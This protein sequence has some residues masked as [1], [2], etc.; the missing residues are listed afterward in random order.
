MGRFHALSIR[1]KLL[2][3]VLLPM[4]GVLPLLGALLLWWSSEAFDRLL[5]T[6]V[7]ADLAVA[8]GYFERVLGE[9]GGSTAALL[10]AL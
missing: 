2:A 7:R 10:T 3:L 9:V 8:Q 5:T 6:K 1:N 4:L